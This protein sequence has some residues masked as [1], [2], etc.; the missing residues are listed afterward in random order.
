[1]NEENA[2]KRSNPS[3]SAIKTQKAPKGAFLC[4]NKADKGFEPEKRA[5]DDERK[6]GVRILSY[7]REDYVGIAEILNKNCN[8]G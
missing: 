5:F 4:F 3:L 7:T 1:M 8:F 6:A 2:A